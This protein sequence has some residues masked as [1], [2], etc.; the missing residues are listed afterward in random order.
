MVDSHCIYFVVLHNPSFSV[1]N[2]LN[3]HWS[4]VVF[5][6]GYKF[7]VP[8]YIE[9]GVFDYHAKRVGKNE[10]Q[11]AVQSSEVGRIITATESSRNLLKTGK[12]PHKVMGTALFEVGE[13]I[14]QRGNVASKSLQTGGAVYVHIERSSDEGTQGTL[15]LQLRGLNI[16]NTQTLGKASPF[17]ELYRKVETPTG[18]IWSSIYKS[19]AVRSN[20]NPKWGETDLNLEVACNGDLD[21]AMKVIVFDHRRSGKH[22]IIGEFE[23]TVRLLVQAKENGGDVDEDNAFTLRKRGEK[24]VGHVLV[25]KAQIVGSMAMEMSRQ[26]AVGGHMLIPQLRPSRRPEF[27]DYLAGGCQISLAVA[28]DFTASNGKW[29]FYGIL[30]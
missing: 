14:G 29:A 18:A 8:F 1:Y 3:P 25:L 30:C 24:K 10:R 12:L 16:S 26:P 19:N 13:V 4:T 7:G 17:F 9:V 20:L 2:N 27:V 23:T 28:I 5:L 22:K 15:L 6:E 21:R 11:L